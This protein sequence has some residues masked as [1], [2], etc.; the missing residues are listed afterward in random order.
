MKKFI[1][2]IFVFSL[3]AHA[4]SSWAC[5]CTP[6]GTKSV[7]EEL[8]NASYVFTGKYAEVIT[9]VYDEHNKMREYV[10]HYEFE[11]DDV[12][13]G[14]LHGTINMSAPNSAPCQRGFADGEEYLVFATELQYVGV[15]SRTKLLSQASD[16]IEQLNKMK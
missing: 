9:E 3:V 8:A 1:I 12:W 10:A 16:D 4:P 13:K 11:V 14:D 6:S 5:S 15:C 2:L 7:A